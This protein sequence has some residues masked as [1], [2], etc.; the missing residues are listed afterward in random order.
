MSKIPFGMNLERIFREYDTSRAGLSQTEAEERLK[1]N[2]KNELV[3]KKKKSKFAIFLNQFKDFM[4]IILIISAL[5]T[6]VIAFVQGEYIEL[7]DAGIILAI[8][9][10]NAFIG[11]FQ[12]CK[13]EDALNKLKD[14]SSPTAKVLRDG[15]IVEIPATNVVVGDV[16]YLEAGDVICA[17]CY[18][19]E[20][21][22]LKCD[23][24]ALTGE[25]IDVEK[26]ADEILGNGTALGDRVN[27]LHSSTVV[28][29]GRGYGVVVAV[30]M[31]TEIGK[32]ARLIE[33]QEEEMTPIQQKLKKL[34]KGITYGVVLIALLVFM[35]N[36]AIG[37]ND[38]VETLM[39]A[40][41]I[42]VAAIP[43]SLNTVITIILSMGVSR[44]SKRN[45]IVKKMHAVETLGSCNVICSDKTGTLTQNKMN[46]ESVFFESLMEGSNLDKENAQNFLNCM[47]LCN[48]TKIKD[49][50]LLGDPTETA[51]VEYCMN[52]G[53]NV[54]KERKEKKRINEIPFDSNRKMMT[55]I[56]KVADKII[57]YTK[58][59]TDVVLG[60]C[61]KVLENGKVKNLSEDDRA[62]IL[63]TIEDLSLKGLRLLAFA[64]KDKR[65]SNLDGKEENEMI[66]LGLVAMRDPP[67]ESSFEA[68]RVCCEAGIKPIMIT[69]DHAL[70]AKSIAQEIGIYK[71][72]DRIL[73]GAELDELSDDEYKEILPTVSVYARV[74]PQNKVRIVECWKSVGAVVAM[75]GDGVNDAPSIKSADIGV[76]MGKVGTEV[77]KNVADMVLVDDN[78]STIVNAVEEGRK[79]YSNIKK[80]IQ[81]LFGTNFVEVLSILLVTI[82]F[83]ALGFFTALQILFINLITDS[84]PALSLSVEKAEK[85][86]MKKPPR[87]KKEKLFAGVL[88][89]MVIQVIWQ[90]ACVVL[91]FAL[92]MQMT[93]DN[94]LAVT[95]AFAVLSLS[96][97]FHLFNV[98]CEKSLFVNN[99]FTNKVFWFTIFLGILINIAVVM[100]EPIAGVFGLVAMNFMQWGMVF[101]I[102]FSI[103]PVI[104]IYK[105]I[106]YLITKRK[107]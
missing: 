38:F 59:A 51:L 77:T 27:M 35:V 22:S 63:G 67:R 73:T 7:I 44:M 104:E 9:I 4:Q 52:L 53:V 105:W 14:M 30:G 6:A 96:Q 83:P 8:V 2:G 15:E 43:E 89:S 68:V 103:I 11:F 74:S 18:V 107:K 86:L 94:A 70:T 34:G 99:I 76:G 33:A 79:T 26:R 106:K 101:L 24:S 90:T 85:D 95:M 25:S 31:D 56:C 55:V 36:M 5:V 102:A 41:A 42:A 80:V 48:D 91:T 3:Q 84:L 20:S 69:G 39:L 60:R 92:C 97:I 46:V 87:E 32:I 13:A 45:A 100:I 10:L 23:E 75:T 1:N 65:D 62:K 98:R 64:Y 21:H 19:M 47:Y 61:N 29:Y 93:G 72:G 17:D 66:F 57:S 50:E 40:I 71:E 16:I 81:F 28:T 12:E 88:G 78:F 49:N 82:L 54:N 58:G 37:K